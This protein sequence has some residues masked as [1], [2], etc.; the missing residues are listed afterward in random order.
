MPVNDPNEP[1]NRSGPPETVSISRA[2][3]EAIDR[4][5]IEHLNEVHRLRTPSPPNGRPTPR[6]ARLEA[7]RAEH[8]PF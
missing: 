1:D 3:L 2:D 6:R 8:P 5:A 4:A 7:L